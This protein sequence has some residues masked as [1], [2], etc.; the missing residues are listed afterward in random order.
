LT[1]SDIFQFARTLALTVREK[2][3]LHVN[4]GFTVSFEHNLV[5]DHPKTWCLTREEIGSPRACPGNPSLFLRLNGNPALFM[6]RLLDSV[7]Y[8]KTL[9]G[10]MC[11]H[12]QLAVIHDGLMEPLERFP[13]EGSRIS[14][15]VPGI[16]TKRTSRSCSP[17]AMSAFH[18]DLRANAVP[19]DVSQRA[20]QRNMDL[21]GPSWQHVGTT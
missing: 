19:Y 20:L 18:P 4:E 9:Q 7:E 2:S 17:C 6:S 5:H 3:C 16:E 12:R 1:A 10:V 14:R 13:A 11:V 8:S 21:I 15:H